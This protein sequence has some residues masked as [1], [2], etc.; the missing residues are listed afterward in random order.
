MVYLLDVIAYQRERNAIILHSRGNLAKFES[1][2][3]SEVPVEMMR[4]HCVYTVGI[5]VLESQVLITGTW[6]KIVI[7]QFPPQSGTATHLDAV[8]IT[9]CFKQI[10]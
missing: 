6:H 2:S 5:G 1:R 8:W 3:Y 9:E 10:A 7:S 4:N